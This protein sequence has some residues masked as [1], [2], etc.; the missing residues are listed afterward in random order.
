MPVYKTKTEKLKIIR[1]GT[2]NVII[3]IFMEI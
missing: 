1:Y 3:E 2:S